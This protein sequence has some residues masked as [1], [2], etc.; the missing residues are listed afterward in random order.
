ML[1]I[2]FV[3]C[4]MCQETRP[5]LWAHWTQNTIKLSGYIVRSV[6]VYAWASFTVICCLFFYLRI[7]CSNFWKCFLVFFLCLYF[8]LCNDCCCK[9]LHLTGIDKELT[10]LPTYAFSALTL[11][12]GRQEG[13]LACKN[14]VVGCWRSY[15]SASRCRLA[16]GPSDASA[17][18]CLLLQ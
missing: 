16:Y 9:C 8:V 3:K 2:L 6:F 10:Y 5:S 12:V 4:L 15:L 7:L 1:F 11:L 17:T 18:R 13:H 14:W